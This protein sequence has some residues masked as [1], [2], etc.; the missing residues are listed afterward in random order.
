MPKELRK[1]TGVIVNTGQL[2]DTIAIGYDDKVN[3][4]ILTPDY[5]ILDNTEYCY[6][7]EDAYYAYTTRGCGMN[8]GFCAVK[9]LEPKV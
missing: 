3:I 7:N 5:S 9:T 1:D 8:C 6:E 4:D 2:T